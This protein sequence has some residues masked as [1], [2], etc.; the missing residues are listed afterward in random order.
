MESHTIEGYLH[1]RTTRYEG[2]L[3]EESLNGRVKGHQG[4]MYGKEQGVGRHEGGGK[5]GRERE[6][7]R[8]KGGREVL[9]P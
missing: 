9:L 8:K 2:K 7:G 5:R 1:E 4:T 3:C 6:R